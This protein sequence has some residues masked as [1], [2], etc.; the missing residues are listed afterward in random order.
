MLPDYF[1]AGYE[2][3]AIRL[4]GAQAG[5]EIPVYVAP[6]GGTLA[7]I[8]Q[9]VSQQI[10]TGSAVVDARVHHISF[11]NSDAPL[12]AEIWTDA[13]QRL[14]R[15]SLPDAAIDV[16]REDIVAASAR[17]RRVSHPGDQDVRVRNEG[18]A[19]AT[20]VTT[21]VD[22]PRPEAGWSAVLLVP[23]AGSGERDGTVSG[24]PVLGQMAGALADAGFLVARYDTRGVGQS[25]GRR[26]SAALDTHADDAKTMVRYLDRRD[27]VDDDRITVLGYADGGWVAMLA[28]RERRAD[29]LVLV[30]APG[31]TGAE[32]VL[33]QQ[34]AELVRIGAGEADRA[35][36]IDLQRRIH[37][38]VL[39]DGSWDG[40]P[41]D[42]RRQAD[43]AWFRS[44]LDFDAADTM[45]RTR[46]PI[47]IVRG[48]LDRQVG[49]HHAER[50]ETLARARR[51]D[52]SV[53]R[54]TLDGVN[55]QLVEPGS[56]A[57]TEYGD[58]RN[59]SI[60][61]SFVDTLTSWLEQAPEL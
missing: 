60:S 25:G 9:V 23:G 7:R 1:F 44:F 17:V 4:A 10:D 55:H 26:E 52:S 11:L 53:T 19:L 31:T 29:A 36:K 50:L 58:L 43:T 57:V 28:A 2:A 61:R 16:A 38:A 54:E 35:E 59:Q 8:D 20:T 39:G 51:R 41:E 48:A 6:R 13:G 37:D 21:P 32:L 34:R 3:L 56:D 22:H 46:Q 12:K 14:L 47:L 45:R 49:A 42:M 5:D 40:V 30:A 24:M 27:D 33:E 15:V 18:F